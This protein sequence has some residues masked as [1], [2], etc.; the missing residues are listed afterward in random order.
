MVSYAAKLDVSVESGYHGFV[1][2]VRDDRWRSKRERP[3]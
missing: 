1:R 3:L 2:K